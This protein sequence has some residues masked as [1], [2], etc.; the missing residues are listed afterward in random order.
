MPIIKSLLGNYKVVSFFLMAF[1]I[2]EICVFLPYGYVPVVLLLVVVI[3]LC[4]R[5]NMEKCMFIL[6]IILLCAGF[7]GPYLGLPAMENIFLFRVLLPI[8]LVLFLFFYKKDWERIRKVRIFL[9]LYIFFIFAMGITLFWTDSLG[10][11]LRY[12]YFLF[13]W[14]YIFFICVYF[15]KDVKSYRVFAKCTVV[16]YILFIS[17]GLWEVI[18][19]MHLPRSGSTFYITTTSEHQPTGFQ[20]NTND[21]AALLTILFPVVINEMS[22]WK[23]RA[24]IIA[25][26]IISV[27]AVYLVIVTFSRMAM[28]VILIEVIILLV[29][30]MRIWIFVGIILGG[31]GVALVS[32]YFKWSLIIQL[33]SDITR[34]FTDKNGSTLERMEMYKATWSLIRDSHFIGIGAGMLPTHLST[35][36]YGFENAS[37]SYWSPHNY[38]LEVLANGG[39]IAFIPLISFFILYFIASLYYWV[40]ARW[41]VESA[42]PF[43]IGVA[44][45]FASIGLSG[46]FDK[47]FLGLGLGIGM[48]I[49]NIYY[50]ERDGKELSNQI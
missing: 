4:I 50:I 43:L 7:F 42:V 8:H 15:L 44:F 36:M 31:L 11:S 9:W 48:S 22:K 40:I 33:F 6:S 2:L 38:W 18:T 34:A 23:K 45:V 25:I 37:A 14:L 21:Y 35:V 13:E 26:S 47:M 46:T 32:Y 49:L 17:I 29:S 19:G 30:W 27:V 39:I 24:A 1:I 28:L 41:K 20:F 16:L 5:I 3:L 10:E 12:I